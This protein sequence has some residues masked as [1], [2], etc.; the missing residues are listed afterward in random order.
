VKT[1]KKQAE[2]KRSAHKTPTKKRTEKIRYM[3]TGEI[4]KV[5]DRIQQHGGEVRTVIAVLPYT[6][7]NMILSVY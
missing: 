4:P 6:E 7:E 2:T 1:V 5:G 3:K